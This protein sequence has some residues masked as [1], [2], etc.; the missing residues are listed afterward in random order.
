MLV[1]NKKNKHGNNNYKIILQKIN[2]NNNNNK[3]R[4]NIHIVANKECH[5][6]KKELRA[7]R[8]KLEN[9]KISSTQTKKKRKQVKRDKMLSIGLILVL[10]S[11][12][13]AVEV[14]LPGGNGTHCVYLPETRVFS[15]RS[16]DFTVECSA[17]ANFSSLSYHLFGIERLVVDKDVSVEKTVFHLYP[18]HVDNTT[19]LNYSM[20]FDGSVHDLVL[21]YGENF[22]SYGI[23]ILEE[24]C[25]EKIYK[26]FSQV[27]DYH[28]IN[29]A[30]PVEP[31]SVSL[32][33][34]VLIHDSVVTKRW[35]YG[36]G[37]WGYPYYG[38]YGYPYSYWYGK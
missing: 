1:W 16:S 26:V 33:G 6:Y 27:V 30:G 2:N 28:V 15:C 23:R 5:V 36:Y 7:E 31:V 20:E 9:L 13:M 12:C 32:L 10:A 19:Y 29:V 34:E 11:A 24:K 38:W 35:L 4:S 37:Y 22:V 14:P 25:W 18:R 3:V 17:A 8:T 21:Y